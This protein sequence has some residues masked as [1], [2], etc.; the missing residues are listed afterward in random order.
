MLDEA[1]ARDLALFAGLA[2]N[3]SD[4][5]TLAPLIDAT[6]VWVDDEQLD[7]IAAPI[8][9]ALWADDLRSDIDRAL[10][11]YEQRHG[12]V[13]AAHA[14]L[15]AGPT[16]SRLALAYVKQG[17]VDLSGAPFVRGLCLCCVEDGL[18]A[19]PL[20]RQKEMVLEAAAAIVF[21]PLSDSTDE[22]RLRARRRLAELGTLAER[23]LPRLAAAFR[24]LAVE[25]LPP[26]DRDALWNAA[27]ALR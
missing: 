7:E 11:E 12:E 24:A 8:V 20:G 1:T 3:E 10:A 2:W 13:H 18:G 26:P 16:G 17:A 5:D 19:A 27:A 23:S 14:D 6:L 22:A 15:D 9:E 25:P 21:D 4:R